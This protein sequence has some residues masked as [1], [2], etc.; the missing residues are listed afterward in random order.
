MK[1]HRFF[2]P[3]LLFVVAL[4]ASGRAETRLA[5]IFGDHMV[6]Q[7]AK[8]VLVWGW[9]DAG[10]EVT[11]TLTE[12]RD[13]AVAA[14]G[15]EALAREP[16][17]P[18]TPKEGKPAKPIVRI[19]Y[20]HENAP[21]FA[22][23]TK[24][25]KAG[26]NGR[27]SVTLAPLQASFSAKFLCVSGGGSKTALIDVLVGE[28]W[29]T[30]GQSNMYSSGD[31]TGWL[32]KEG[33][34]MPGVR[35]AHTGKANSYTPQ[36]DLP[37]PV[38]WIPCEGERVRGIS[39]IPYLFGKYLH[40]KLEVPVGVVNAAS[41]GA[42]GHYWC[43]WDQ[44][45]QIEFENVSRMIREETAAIE[46][47]E[48]PDSRKQILAD[49]EKAYAEQLAAWE[50]EKQQAEDENKRPPRQP[51]HKPP[52]GPKRPYMLGC[53]FN[54]RISP[55]RPLA[56]RGVLYLQ[57]EQQVLAWAVTRYRYI[58][59]RVITSFR[60]AFGD[61][62]LPF[63]IISLQGPGHNKMSISEMGPANRTA[64]VREVQ[65]QAHLNTSDT[66]FI[67]SHDVG[68]GLHPNWKR[69]VAERAVHWA[70]RSVYKTIPDKSWSV[71]S[72]EYE[73]G[74][75]YV[76][77][78][79][80]GVQ[81]RRQGKDWIDEP[82]T[83]PAKIA[84]W[85]GNDGQYLGGF[86]VAGKDRRWYPAE[87]QPNREKQALEVWSDLVAEPI[88]VRYGWAGF[89]VAN[90]GPWEHP[91]APFRTDDWSTFESSNLDEKI[92][93][94]S[95]S[96]WYRTLDDRY[97]DMLDRT[98]RQGGFDAAHSEMLI[99]G[100]AAGILLSKADRL[101]AILDEMT[102]DFYRND[103]LK[104]LD[105]TDWTIRRCNESHLRQAAEVP[106]QMDE[107][108]G[109]KQLQEK[110]DSLRKAIEEYRKAVEKIET[111]EEPSTPT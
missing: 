52:A 48:D 103:K 14:V 86:L 98:I 55:I 5:N 42:F 76:R 18:P 80:K 24:K 101:L 73:N 74:R 59:P 25:T 53:L 15:A 66:G 4:Q 102:G 109:N 75:A 94:K 49:Y 91:L 13:Q 63:G 34:L 77:I 36:G 29:V 51:E 108:L 9:A 19:T 79:E 39:T 100:A 17:T 44:L 92:K 72:I 56:I 93:Q 84:T 35:Y 2:V 88:A 30:A 68:R 45:R 32:D 26:S 31:K 43:S 54:G 57:G 7:Q 97:V 62:E 78:V 99:H 71:D 27:W 20:A 11:V 104:M 85:S 10:T 37:A 8:P 111:E 3:A 28:V 61:D 41:G 65:Y 1:L 12:S 106:E 23:V 60:A 22:A 105:F 67:C 47:W 82:V 107:A 58:F 16:V 70:L 81:R 69:P 6:L 40:R 90:I 95:R 87:V 96:D 64:V 110:I 33:L 21:P 89:P 38:D 50:K 83:R 46:A